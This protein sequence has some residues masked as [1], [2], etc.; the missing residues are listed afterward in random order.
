VNSGSTPK[1]RSCLTPS[2]P[3]P[4]LTLRRPSAV[5][6]ATAS[7]TVRGTSPDR[8]TPRPRARPVEV[9]PVRTGRSRR[10]SVLRVLD[11]ARRAPRRLL[12][13]ATALSVVGVLGP[14]GTARAAALAGQSVLFLVIG[15]LSRYVTTSFAATQRPG[16]YYVREANFP[17]A[18]DEMLDA[19]VPRAGY[20]ARAGATRGRG[21]AGRPS[22]RATPTPSAA[23]PSTAAPDRAGGRAAP[24]WSGSRAPA[25]R[26]GCRRTGHPSCI[27]HAP[28][29]A[30]R[31]AEAQAR[32]CP[33]ELLRGGAGSGLR[34]GGARW[35]RRSVSTAC[36]ATSTR[37]T[38]GGPSLGGTSARWAWPRPSDAALRP[39]RDVAGP[40]F[41]RRGRGKA[42]G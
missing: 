23:P 39:A 10:R 35:T 28:L 40:V 4:A 36:R 22:W 25:R 16:L 32:A 26:Q 13:A 37:F 7:R 29:P 30:S 31:I 12:A 27:D 18:A 1:P 2:M 9:P 8:P 14:A 21:S 3:V 20:A 5:S 24:R 15:A 38:S 33:R 19:D 6:H 11:P 41:R 17:V 42:G 34:Q